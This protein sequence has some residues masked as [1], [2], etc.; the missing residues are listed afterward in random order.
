MAPRHALLLGLLNAMPLVRG[1]MSSRWLPQPTS[2]LLLTI[3]QRA[4]GYHSRFLAFP[5]NNDC[6]NDIRLSQQPSPI[7]KNHALTCLSMVR[8]NYR[9]NAGNNDSRSNN[10]RNR[11]PRRQR[12]PP[13]PMPPPGSPGRGCYKELIA[14]GLE[15]WVVQKTDQRSGEE[16][17]GMVDRL[18]T[19]SPYHPRG[20]KVMLVSGEV[21]RVTRIVDDK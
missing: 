2:T 20:I 5:F 11:R 9:S 13:P 7:S 21:G 18:L 6:N 15:V 1:L 8:R 3:P 16:T 14:P 17:R 10:N 19:N 12:S 4:L